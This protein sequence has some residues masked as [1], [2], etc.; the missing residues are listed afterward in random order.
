[1]ISIRIMLLLKEIEKV[2]RPR[3][4]NNI[5]IKKENIEKKNITKENNES[6]ISQ[7]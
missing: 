5:E 7:N 2:P 1:M 3:K 4:V 6:D